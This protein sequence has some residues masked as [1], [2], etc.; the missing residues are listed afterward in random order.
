MTETEYWL[1]GMEWKV[2]T[3]RFMDVLVAVEP[4]IP[5]HRKTLFTGYIVM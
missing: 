2:F 3:K 1:A 4:W 5:H